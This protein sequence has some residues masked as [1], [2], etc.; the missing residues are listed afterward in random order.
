MC[1]AT[2]ANLPSDG[3]PLLLN[4]HPSIS[5]V[6]IKL[7]A[8]IGAPCQAQGRY[9]GASLL[10]VLAMPPKAPCR[11]G[12]AYINIFYRSEVLAHDRRPLHP[13]IS[14]PPAQLSSAA[15]YLSTIK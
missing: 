7:G 4:A 10:D 8:P 3:L 9:P 14:H 5:E 6:L 13:V 12:Y 15:A 1:L 11:F 2:S